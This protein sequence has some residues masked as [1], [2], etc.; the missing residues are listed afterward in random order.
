[1]TPPQTLAEQAAQ[2]LF[3]RIGSNMPPPTRVEEDAARVEALVARVPV[4][5]LCLFNGTAEATPATLRHLQ[6][7][8]RYPLLVA[9]DMER[10]TGQQVHGATVFPHALAFS[11]LGGDGPAFAERFARASAREA[12]ACGIH[13]AFAPVA[14]VNRE[15][16]NPIIA[17]RAFG[18]VP[19]ATAHL[20]A[21]YVR[22][23]RAEGLLTTAK[24]FPGHGGTAQDS[25]AELPVVEDDRAALERTD[26]VPF[27]AALAAGVDAVM[28]AHIVYPALDPDHPATFSRAILDGLLRGE[29]G[30]EGPVVTDSLLMAAVRD[31]Y[32][33]PGDQAAVLLAAGVDV[34]LDVQE[35]EAAWHGIQAAV[36]EGRLTAA[37][38]E[39][40]CRRVW[41]LKQH[42]L[43]RFGPAAFLAPATLFR[44]D[45]VGHPDHHALALEVARRALTPLDGRPLPAPEGDLAVVLVKPIQT[46]LDPPV[47]PLAAA[48]RARH[49]PMQYHQL[50]PE[51]PPAAW[52]AAERALRR[53]AHRVVAVAVRPAA[54][55]AFGLPPAQRDGVARLVAV[56]GVHLVALGSPQ[57]LEG[58]DGA[59]RR[60]CTFSDA[61][62]AQQALAAYLA[63]DA[64]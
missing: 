8:S 26:L 51:A 47:E 60:L 28:T 25:H 31:A 41:R 52:E 19:E 18:T 30:F 59:A 14:D 40:A 58:L 4:G 24:H 50:G 54:W 21:A 5:G 27:R 53:A 37:R 48:L 44:P 22:G 11:A 63:G 45:E 43:D 6:S 32:G 56:G 57:G 33:A 1:M 46:R 39:E 15:P 34:L 29:M 23:A 61:P 42:L 38:V 16:R 64:G 55:H 13:L 9:T 3:P 2:L 35:P 17:T 12:L 62:P 49:V 10:G 7:V 36:A 20:V